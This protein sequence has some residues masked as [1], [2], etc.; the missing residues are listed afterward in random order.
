MT[1]AEFFEQLDARIAKYDL[2]CHPFYKAWAAG[3]LTRGDLREYAANYFHQVNTFPEYLGDFASRLPEGQMKR[4]VLANRDEEIGRDGSRPHADLWL[5]FLE[6][7]GGGRK[8]A[9]VPAAEVS[10]LTASFRSVAHDAFREEALAA[11]YAYESQVPRVAAEKARGLREMYGADDKTCEYFTL[12]TTADVYHSR[13]W[14]NQLAKLVETDTDAAERALNA[15][16]N[17]A[18]A[19]WTAL[20]GIEAA[21]MARAA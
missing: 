1:T 14:K 18:K 16:E 9:E 13:V 12:H 17:A 4:A 15:G 10:E 5:D 11:F 3:E 21:R 6:G 8:P 2:L 20:D 19:L 7:M